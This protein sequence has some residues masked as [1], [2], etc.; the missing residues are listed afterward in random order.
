MD[1]VDD[2]SHWD[3]AL[4][5]TGEQ[6]SALIVKKDANAS[7][8]SERIKA[9]PVYLR[10]ERSF[11]NFCIWHGMVDSNQQD[12]ELSSDQA[13]FLASVG[14][15]DC[16]RGS[17]SRDL[18]NGELSDFSQLRLSRKEIARW[19][20]VNGLKSAY[21]FELPDV[22]IISSDPSTDPADYPDELY[23]A[24]LAFRAVT[25]GYG[26]TSDTFKNRLVSYL[27]NTH[28]RL[29]KEAV[30][31]IATVANPDKSTGRKKSG[32]E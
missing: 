29:S 32:K 3:F 15:E 18:F 13:K 22:N 21:S 16:E 20:R 6:A 7:L 25:N 5:F 8:D 12:C 11:R 4:D 27:E 31:R 28:A 26:E 10:M 23:A 9:F 17:L 2:L 14:L 30:Q 1:D 24:N 19:L